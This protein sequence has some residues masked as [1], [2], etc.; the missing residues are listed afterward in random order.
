MRA[1]KFNIERFTYCP[2]RCSDFC[3]WAPSVSN[4]TVGEAEGEMVAWCSKPGH[5]TRLIPAGA[6]T[7]VQFLK[8]PDY[9]QIVGFIDQTKVN[10]A[11]GDYGGEMDPHGADLV[12]LLLTPTGLFILTSHLFSVE[13]L[14][15]VLCIRPA[16][17]GLILKL[18]NGLS[19]SFHFFFVP[20][21]SDINFLSLASLV[22]MPSV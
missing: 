9:I 18:S 16:S 1:I 10:I 17:Q 11:G 20:N 7:G 2:Y 8:T 3:L 6:L 21:P 5:G 14:W 12:C 22:V 4:K 15:E 19:L 13:T